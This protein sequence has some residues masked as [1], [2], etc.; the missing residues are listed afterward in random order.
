MNLINDYFR[1]EIIPD[2]DAEFLIAGPTPDL[3]HAALLQTINNSS[4][5]RKL[6]MRP[7]GELFF[8]LGHQVIMSVFQG[9]PEINGCSQFVGFDWDSNQSDGENDP[10]LNYDALQRYLSMSVYVCVP[11]IK[12]EPPDELLEQSNDATSYHSVP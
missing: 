12:E 5:S 9:M 4:D 10:T 8:G 2:Q 3:C 1:F 7:H 11:E 6:E